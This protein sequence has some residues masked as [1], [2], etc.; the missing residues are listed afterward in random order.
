MP[1]S[2]AKHPELNVLK[3]CVS[4]SLAVFAEETILVLDHETVVLG[5]FHGRNGPSRVL[6]SSQFQR[7]QLPHLAKY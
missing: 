2:L 3:T 6:V 1:G 7:R 4:G 5:S